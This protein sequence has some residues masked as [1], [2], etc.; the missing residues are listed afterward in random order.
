MLDRES[1]RERILE[2]K[3]REIRIKIKKEQEEAVKVAQQAA[4][5]AEM[6]DEAP[7][8][9]PSTSE[10]ECKSWRLAGARSAIIFRFQF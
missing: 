4:L 10:G 1:K 5:A 3:L 7:V 2:G 6:K 8:L 9:K